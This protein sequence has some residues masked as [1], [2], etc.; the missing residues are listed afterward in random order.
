MPMYEYRCQACGYQYEVIQK[1]SDPE[2]TDCPSCGE[3]QLKKL[4]SMSSF[5]LRGGGWYAD[6]Y[7]GPSAEAEPK[8]ESKD[9][10]GP[11][12]SKTKEGDTKDSGSKPDTKKDGGPPKTSEPKPKG[13]SSSQAAS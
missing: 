8:A 11:E 1:F 2:L 6:G 3:A 9:A 10:S 12:S 4:M 13:P 5:A 7:G